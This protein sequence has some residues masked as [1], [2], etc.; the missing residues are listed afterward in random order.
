[1][2]RSFN[3]CEREE[4]NGSIIIMLM[5]WIVREKIV[6]RL[7]ASVRFMPN[8][9]LFCFFVLKERGSRR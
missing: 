3:L 2:Y 7:H 4:K 8:A 5:A 1:M 6:E 9:V